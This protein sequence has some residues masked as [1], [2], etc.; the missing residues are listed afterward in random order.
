VLGDDGDVVTEGR[1][2]GKGVQDQQKS[3]QREALGRD[4]ISQ[5]REEVGPR[6]IFEC[7]EFIVAPDFQPAGKGREEVGAAVKADLSRELSKLAILVLSGE[8]TV[9]GMVEKLD[10]SEVD[11]S[12]EEPETERLEGKYIC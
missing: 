11:P 6:G 8:Q 10:A 12:S 1:C 2:T 4:T 5:Q 9:E 3:H 7:D